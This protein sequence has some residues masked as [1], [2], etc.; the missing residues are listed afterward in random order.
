MEH[1][2][3]RFSFQEPICPAW[4]N[5]CYRLSCTSR[6]IH[7]LWK[8]SIVENDVGE[9]KEVRGDAVPSH[10][11]YKVSIVDHILKVCHGLGL[12]IATGLSLKLE[13]DGVSFHK[14]RD[15][16][17]LWQALVKSLKGCRQYETQYCWS[18]TSIFQCS[19]FR[20]GPESTQFLRLWNTQDVG[21]K[22]RRNRRL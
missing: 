10:T 6:T 9:D 21:Y 14:S 2:V 16:L 22:L 5:M 18:S 12:R 17:H 15:Y 4:R 20:F 13:M 7:T 3:F 8:T 11:A 1:V 19:V